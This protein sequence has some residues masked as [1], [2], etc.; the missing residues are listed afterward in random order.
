[1]WWTVESWVGSTLTAN[2]NW[3]IILNQSDMNDFYF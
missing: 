1:M 2:N 3:N